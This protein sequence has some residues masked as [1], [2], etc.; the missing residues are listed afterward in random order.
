MEK[1]MSHTGITFAGRGIGK[2]CMH[3]ATQA[4]LVKG[5]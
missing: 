4:L 2:V 1:A 5:Y 3:Q